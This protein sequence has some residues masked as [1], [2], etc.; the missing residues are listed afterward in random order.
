MGRPPQEQRRIAQ[1]TEDIFREAVET[2]LVE[3]YFWPPL[4]AQA[5]ADSFDVD[6]YLANDISPEEACLT[7]V[8]RWA[9][10]DD[11]YED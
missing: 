4:A 6:D 3:T 8:E 9:D 2:L 10:E 11:Y 7:E 1:V 5:F